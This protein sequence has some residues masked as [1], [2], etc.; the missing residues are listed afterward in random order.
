MERSKHYGY[1][2]APCAEP[3]SVKRAITLVQAELVA[4][5]GILGRTLHA[6][7]EESI[8]LQ[9]PTTHLAHIRRVA[10]LLVGIQV[11]RLAVPGLEL[12]QLV[13]GRGMAYPLNR[14]LVSHE[15][16]IR[17]LLQIVEEF[18]NDQK[19]IKI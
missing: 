6:S 15:E 8:L 13:A 16:H 14:L 19:G 18:L 4:N 9:H 7:V 3:Y 11:L 5:P 2:K 1:I 17:Q 12:V 10:D